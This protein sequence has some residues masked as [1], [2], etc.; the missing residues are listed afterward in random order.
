MMATATFN[1]KKFL[2]PSATIMAEIIMRNP[3]AEDNSEK[4]CELNIDAHVHKEASKKYV[5]F[6]QH[7][8]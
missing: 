1:P 3:K 6:Q 4:A 5:T 8:M 7:E 2:L